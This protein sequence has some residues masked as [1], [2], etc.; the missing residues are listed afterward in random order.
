M[1]N[2]KATEILKWYLENE[3]L[4]DE[5]KQAFQMAVDALAKSVTENGW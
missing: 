2:S 1:D 3:N 5:E 4:S